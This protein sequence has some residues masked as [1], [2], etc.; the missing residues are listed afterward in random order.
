MAIL[1]E[2]NAS[3]AALR[4]GLTKSEAEVFGLARG[5]LGPDD[6]G[7]GGAHLD[8]GDGGRDLVATWSRHAV[9]VKTGPGLR[10][11]PMTKED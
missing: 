9:T 1:R 6:D 4:D 5:Y 2:N 3:L 8:S 11:G 7:R 10:P